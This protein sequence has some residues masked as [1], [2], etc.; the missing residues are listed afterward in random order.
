[1]RADC[2]AIGIS[3]L[4]RITRESHGAAAFGIATFKKFAQ[5]FILTV[6]QRVHWVDDDGLNAAAV[7]RRKTWSTMGTM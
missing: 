3:F 7:P 5:L 4:T 1:M 6:C 2:L